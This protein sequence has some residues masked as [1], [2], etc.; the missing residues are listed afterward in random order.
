MPS[1]D[2]RKQVFRLADMD[3][4]IFYEICRDHNPMH[5]QEPEC[6]EYQRKELEHKRRM[7]DL[8]HNPNNKNKTSKSQH[9]I[10]LF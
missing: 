8:K 4:E 2:Y 6:V 3:K 9:N 1:V 10:C 7:E 5:C